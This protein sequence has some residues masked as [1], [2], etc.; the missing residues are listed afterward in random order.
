M[1]A[2]RYSFDR[3]TSD[4]ARG[5]LVERGSEVA[6]L[7]VRGFGFVLMLVGFFV[8]IKVIL[9]AWGLYLE[10]TGIEPFAQAI[11]RGSGL[12]QAIA[13]SASDES[14]ADSDTGGAPNLSLSYFIAWFVAVLLLML[15]GRLSIEAMRCGGELVLY[16]VPLKRFIK[17]LNRTA[18][19][20]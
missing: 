1:S 4:A 11:E 5:G 7:I 8:A 18:G 16:D 20:G 3:Q 12:D 14:A 10:P 6:V 13:A 19:R 9:T 2:A 15:I 17:E